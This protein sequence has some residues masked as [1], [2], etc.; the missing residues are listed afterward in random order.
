VLAPLIEACRP[1]RKTQ[2]HDLR[3]TV[4]AIIWRCLNRAGWRS[5]PVAFSPRAGPLTGTSAAMDDPPP[6]D[7][8]GWPRRP[9]SALGGLLTMVQERGVQPGMTFLDGSNIWAHQEAAGAAQKRAV[10]PDVLTG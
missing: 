8:G 9:S 7:H 5:L 6:E 3:R 4:E 1:H 10:E 2:H